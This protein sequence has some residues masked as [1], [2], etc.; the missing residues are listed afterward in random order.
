VAGAH[1]LG[2]RLPAPARGLPNRGGLCGGRDPRAV[3]LTILAQDASLCLRAR[4]LGIREAWR[5]MESLRCMPVAGNFKISAPLFLRI[6][7]FNLRPRFALEKPWAC[8][9]FSTFRKHTWFRTI[10]RVLASAQT[11]VSR[12]DMCGGDVLTSFCQAATPK[13][14]HVGQGLLVLIAA[15]AQGGENQIR[16]S[17]EAT[18]LRS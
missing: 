5:P 7:C 6:N 8:G 11:R 16:S 4:A 2:A 15:R 12:F 10:I 17:V 1:R 14:L 18:S 9:G 13:G 3:I